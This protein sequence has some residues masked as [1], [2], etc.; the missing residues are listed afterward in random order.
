[1]TLLRTVVALS[2]LTVVALAAGDARADDAPAPASAEPVVA[3]SPRWGLV[4]AGAGV[5]G[6]S[7]GVSVLVALSASNVTD[8]DHSAYGWMAVP[9][10]GPFITMATAP[11]KRDE[12]LTVPALGAAQILGAGLAAAGFVFPRARVIRGATAR[13]EIVPS[14]PAGS[15]GLSV[16]GTF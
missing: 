4:G 8:V 7:Y 13:A 10:A 3:R 5:F 14:G 12:R 16:V 11:L 1:M 9:I 2:A 15:T 6:L